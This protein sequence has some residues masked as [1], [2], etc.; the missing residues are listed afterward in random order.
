IEFDT[1]GAGLTDLVERVA[2]LASY[3]IEH[4][5]VVRDGNTVG[6]SDVERLTV[7]HRTSQRCA[8]LPVYAIAAPARGGARADLSPLPPD[9]EVAS[10]VGLPPRDGGVLSSY[11]DGV[12]GMFGKFERSPDGARAEAG[13]GQAARNVAG[14]VRKLRDAMNAAIQDGR[15]YA[16]AGQQ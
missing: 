11:I 2:G 16:Y 6:E 14:E 5:P 12:R 4:G 8:G 10:G 3:L 1:D 9:H 13:D 15:L 7:R